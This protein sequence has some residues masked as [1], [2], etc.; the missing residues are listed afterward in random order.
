MPLTDSELAQ[1]EGKRSKMQGGVT[2][3]DFIK[4]GGGAAI[5]VAAGLITMY[6]QVQNQAQAQT[7]QAQQITYQ[8]T[9]VANALTRIDVKLDT[10]TEKQ[11]AQGRQLDVQQFRL[12]R[13]DRL[14]SK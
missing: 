1:L 11:E 9:Q 2:L 14:D 4:L 3:G 5:S 12:N 10:I 6:V 8:Q 13:I 7:Q